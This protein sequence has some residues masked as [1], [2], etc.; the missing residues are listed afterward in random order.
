M[1]TL[2]RSVAAVVSVLDFIPEDVDAMQKEL[3]MWRAEAQLNCTALQVEHRSVSH[4]STVTVTLGLHAC[5]M[6]TIA[7]TLSRWLFC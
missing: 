4:L 3:R 5:R 7:Y 2:T 1:Q 6:L